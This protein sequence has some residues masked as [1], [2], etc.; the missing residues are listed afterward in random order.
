[1]ERIVLVVIKAVK[2]VIKVVNNA[3]RCDQ[4]VLFLNVFMVNKAREKCEQTNS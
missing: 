1:M 4:S 3:K 2:V